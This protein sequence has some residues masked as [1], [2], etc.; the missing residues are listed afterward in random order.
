MIVPEPDSTI[1]CVAVRSEDDMA[2]K[3]LHQLRIA[4]PEENGVADQS[5]LKT[6]DHI[7]NRPSPAFDATPLKPLEA[8]VF[9]VGFASFVR[10]MSQFKRND[11]AIEYHRRPE[12]RA[13]AEE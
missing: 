12:A 11:H 13:C 4:T 10:Q 3:I 8:D 5:R 6:L 9:F 1:D 7:E 2:G